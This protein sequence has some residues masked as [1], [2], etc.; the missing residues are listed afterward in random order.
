MPL[1][2]LVSPGASIKPKLKCVGMPAGRLLAAWAG[3]GAERKSTS[4]LAAVPSSST[5]TASSMS[6]RERLDVDEMFKEA[7]LPDERYSGAAVRT[8]IPCQSVPAEV[9]VCHT[10][11]SRRAPVATAEVSHHALPRLLLTLLNRPPDATAVLVGHGAILPSGGR[12]RAP[13]LAQK[14]RMALR[15]PAPAQRLI[16]SGRGQQ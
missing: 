4:A 3:A 15:V 6:R 2:E 11:S 16:D 5:G 8:G 1:R 14:Y 10:V 13:R 9:N 12:A 7:L